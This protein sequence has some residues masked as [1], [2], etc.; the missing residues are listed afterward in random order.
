[1]LSYLGLGIVLGVSSPISSYPVLI[2]YNLLA[3]LVTCVGSA[4]V[5]LLSLD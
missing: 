3:K 4:A 1:M 2:F 5:A